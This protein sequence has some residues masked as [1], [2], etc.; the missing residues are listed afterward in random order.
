MNN[1]SH[2]LGLSFPT[3]KNSYKIIWIG[4]AF[5]LSNGK[6]V[7]FHSTMKH[8]NDISSMIGCLQLS[9]KNLHFHKRNKTICTYVLCISFFIL[10][11]WQII[12]LYCKKLKHF[13]HA[14]IAWWK[15]HQ[16]LWEFSSRWSLICYQILP[17]VRLSFQRTIV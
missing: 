16:S 2:V 5:W 7:C 12:V 1:A 4:R 15:P 9:C 17:N 3:I 14:F 13:L 8:E 10:L 6:Q 11:S